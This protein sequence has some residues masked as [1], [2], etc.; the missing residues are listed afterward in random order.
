MAGTE[1]LLAELGFGEY[2]GRA[3]LS[4]LGHGPA[5]G[6][7]L[8]KLS[9]IPRGNIYNVLQKLEDRGAVVHMDT[10]SGARFS[11]LPVAELLAGL[12]RRYKQT[13]AAA[14][15]QLSAVAVPPDIDPVW[16]LNGYDALLEHGRGILAQATGSLLIAI[17]PPEAKALAADL[18]AAHRRG[19]KIATLCLTGCPHECSACRGS[20]HRYELAAKDLTRT[21]VIVSAVE[22]GGDMVAGEIAPAAQGSVLARGIRSRQLLLVDLAASY[23]RHS[24]ALAALLADPQTGA[25]DQLL[26]ETRRALGLL[27]PDSTAAAWLTMFRQVLAAADGFNSPGAGTKPR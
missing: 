8:A 18:D 17:W 10:S 22:R 26:P 11:A 13:L 12:E 3:Y 14:G 1:Q 20:I 15:E 27:A 9:G 21:I 25:T 24:I 23:V 16:N 7:E 5:N 4:L 19:L 2:E 6:Y